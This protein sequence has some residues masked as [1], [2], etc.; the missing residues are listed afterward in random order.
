MTPE[1]SIISAPNRFGFCEGVAWEWLKTKLLTNIQYELLDTT[2]PCVPRGNKILLLGPAAVRQWAGVDVDIF[3]ARGTKL[4]VANRL[5]TCSFD[6]QDSYDFKA[7]DETANADAMDKDS[8]STRK[9]NWFFWLEADI[10][11]LLSVPAVVHACDYRIAPVIQTITNSLLKLRGRTLYLDIETDMDSDTLSC[12]GFAS[13]TS[14]VYVVPVYNYKG[15]LAYDRKLLLAFL[16]A[17]GV[18]MTRNRV[19]IHNAMFDL[20]FLA[21]KYRLPFGKDIYDT[22]LAHQRC[23]SEIEKSL[24]HAV[25]LWT[26]QPYHKDMATRVADHTSENR[27]YVYNANDVYSMRLVHRAI[28]AYAAGIPGLADS[29]QQANSSLYPY[30]LAGLHGFRID[31]IALAEHKMIVDRRLVQLTRIMRV[32]TNRPKFN[33]D[34]PKQVVDYFHNELAYKV[35]ERSDSGAPSLG[36][37]ALYSLALRYP[38]PLIQ[39]LLHYRELSMELTMATF[40]GFS[41]PWRTDIEHQIQ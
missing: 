21:S 8:T 13:D 34:S 26:W 31:E 12:V 27:L 5:A 30:L 36:S 3:K 4:S 19:V 15:V 9:A 41:L 38:N 14:P 16:Q 25:S 18:A 1:L 28:E 17:L 39:I 29:I 2:K 7:D 32:L 23:Y 6:P 33:P 11:K 35:V 37:K 10:R 22:M 40:H 20:A 24:G